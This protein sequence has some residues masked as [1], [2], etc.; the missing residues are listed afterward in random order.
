[1][2]HTP[3]DYNLVQQ[4]IKES[5]LK[6]VG[7]AS[8]REIRTL[9]NN[10]ENES[11]VKFIRMEMGV[12]GL[13]AVKIGIE[14]E[15]KA[16]N[17]GVGSSYPSIEGLPE[18]KQEIARFVKLF[19]DI[20]TNENCCIPCTGSTNG[21][22]ICFLVAERRD[23]QKDTTLFLDPG[24]PVHKLQLQVLGLKQMSLDVYEYRGEKLRAKLEEI[25][26]KGNISTILY[27]NPNNP[28]WICFT[29]KEL[30]II[31]EMANKYDVIILEDLA[32]LNMDFRKEYS[33]PGLP[34]YQPTVAKYTDNYIMLISS[35]KIFSYAGQRIGA[36]A[37]SCK[38]FNR[39][40]PDLMQYYTS[41]NFGHA[42]IYGAAYAV[43]AGVTH[44]TQYALTALL[45]A[46]N[47]GEYNFIEQVKI[48]GRRA[49]EMKR[50]FL[51]NGFHIVYDEDD[52]VP[53]ADGFYFTVSYPGLTGEELIGELIYY[54]ISAI[55]LSN[56]GSLRK[57]G[58]RACVS[59]VHESQFGD[60]EK[61]LKMFHE[62][63]INTV[64]V[65]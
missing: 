63:H 6:C 47:D 40:F 10:I 34:P 5:K 53:I 32:Y 26:S 37:I 11:N 18:L 4:K 57:E 29:D 42:L 13:P 46:V 16:L 62:N 14:A 60:L 55:S 22:F 49:K 12:P 45:K 35:S 61:R 27:S 7:K 9:I 15:A 2:I 65:K 52:G 54:G 59:H 21:S 56:T 19:L 1:M 23:N 43:S 50:I 28:S 58:I 64:P 38:L 25:L 33:K 48:Y 51:E 39:T 31:G 44:S 24:F 41:S 20:D 8:I 17:N 3:I 30:Q 36:I